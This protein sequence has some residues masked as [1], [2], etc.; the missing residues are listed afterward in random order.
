MR[1][2]V[3]IRSKFDLAG[4]YLNPQQAA[5]VLDCIPFKDI[6]FIR[7]FKK[8]EVTTTGEQVIRSYGVIPDD[9]VI[10]IHFIPKGS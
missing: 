1:I 3:H 9:S 10:T 7:C 2:K 4:Q 8:I 5:S 6:Q